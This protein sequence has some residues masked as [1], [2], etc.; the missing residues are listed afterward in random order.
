MRI[1]YLPILLGAAT[2]LLLAAPVSGTWKGEGQPL[3]YFILEELP[4][5]TPI[6]NVA[7]DYKLTDK[8][9]TTV[10]RTLRYNI[11]QTRSTRHELF[12][13][14][15]QTAI[16]ST[17]RRIDRDSACA[18]EETCIA[19]LHIHVLP[20]GFTDDIQIMLE[21]V[22]KNDNAP[23]F[24]D[25]SVNVTIVE[26]AVPGTVYDL[27]TATDKDSGNNGLRSYELVSD[28]DLFELGFRTQEGD[29]QRPQ[30]KLAGRVDR[31]QGAYY[32]LALVAHD[33]GSP[34]RSGSVLVNVTVEDVND[35]DPR[36]DNATYTAT[37]RENLPAG[38]PVA[39]VRARDFDL[40]DNA[41][42]TYAFDARTLTQFGDAFDI[43]PATGA[44]TTKRTLDFEKGSIYLL[45]VLARDRGGQT[46]QPAQATVVVRVVD[47]NDNTP[48]I[49]IG[50][51]SLT[52]GGEIDVAEDVS[53]GTLVARLA[54]S[55]QDGGDNGRV[56]CQLRAQSSLAAFRLQ[57]VHQAQFRLVTV[58]QLDRETREK[59]T[60]TVACHDLGTPPNVATQDVI[61]H[62]TDVNDN[63]PV[64]SQTLYSVRMPS[65]QPVNQPFLEVHATDADIGANGDIRYA[66]HDNAATM[67]YVNPTSGAVSTK[68]R[69]AL[70]GETHIR[71][72]VVAFDLGAPSRTATA[73]VVLMDGPPP[74]EF[75]QTNFEFGVFENFPS[76][77]EV[78]TVTVRSAKPGEVSFSL[79]GEAESEDLFSIDPTT[80]TIK[81]RTSFDREERPVYY[82]TA[83][84][85]P[86]AS[87]E[88]SASVSVTVYVADQNDNSPELLYPTD[89]NHTVYLPPA[90]PRGL[91]VAQMRARDPDLGGNGKLTYSLS[92]GNDA[93]VFALSPTSGVLTLV[94]DLTEGHQTDAYN[95]QLLVSDSGFPR[96][97]ARAR[98]EVVVNRSS[99]GVLR[100]GAVQGEDVVDA[101]YATVVVAV[102]A[103]CLI[104][105][106]LL[107]FAI[108]VFLIWRRMKPLSGAGKDRPPP[109]N[110]YCYSNME[111]PE[112]VVDR[113]PSV[114]GRA[115]QG[116]PADGPHGASLDRQTGYAQPGPSGTTA[117]KANIP[118][119]TDFCL[120]IDCEKPQQPYVENNILLQ[121]SLLD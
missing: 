15:Q 31:E 24:Q 42:V 35:H 76:Y 46:S 82:M 6:G 66:V 118:K 28:S 21:I 111:A 9:N 16:V 109:P 97:V 8:L 2:A 90:A 59:Y 95:L 87:P 38:A 45:V 1:T 19:L 37:V 113:A 49:D 102:T 116:R 3:E 96:F 104:T 99:V 56:D 75:S 23:V 105:V 114:R 52:P 47:E 48:V 117:N 115:R 74:P 69:V 55:D 43:D 72:R 119:N 80:G 54:V 70:E 89:A 27:P 4:A 83:V 22:D 10:L 36:F 120:S 81:T 106:F 107:L 67:F 33:A 86:R 29:A 13:I 39:T 34:P 103:A 71:F 101:S 12:T 44:V 112:E 41:A 20:P 108:M 121:V 14:D 94:K 62:V 51:T 63:I 77:T 18:G 84:A 110:Q 79:S 30:L 73:T 7:V 100:T 88:A 85:A 26:S 93:G 17:S 25:S 11:D 91:Q 64:F 58:E 50:P 32:S 5:G 92:A 65:D 53:P 78:G 57:R 68:T 40:G 61:V 60:L 98:L